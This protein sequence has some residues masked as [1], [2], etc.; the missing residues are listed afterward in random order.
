MTSPSLSLESSHNQESIAVLHCPTD[1]TY[2]TDQLPF[3]SLLEE[4]IIDSKSGASTSVLAHQRMLPGSTN[5]V[6]RVDA[7]QPDHARTNSDLTKKNMSSPQSTASPPITK[8]GQLKP[9]L[10]NMQWRFAACFFS[11][12]LCGWGDGGTA[13]CAPLNLC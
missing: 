9:P 5:H 8:K 2:L 11:Y 1:T 4:I 10:E 13:K 12:F 3:G 6:P 7:V